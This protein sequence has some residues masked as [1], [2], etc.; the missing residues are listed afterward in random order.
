MSS[1]NEVG[2]IY[3]RPWGSYKTLEME[4]GFQVKSITVN[5]GGRLSLQSH[6]KRAEHWV[7]VKG[8]PTVTIN[9]SVRD[10]EENEAIYIPRQAK[11]RLENFTN[12]TVMI[13]EVQVGSY[14]GEDDIVRY[15]DIYGRNK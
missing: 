11:H 6:E 14:L 10:Y 12:H 1:I 3:H 5:P 2:K 15:D 9:E 8:K 4:N 7:V 13:V